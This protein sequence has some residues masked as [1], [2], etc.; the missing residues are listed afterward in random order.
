MAPVPTQNVEMIEGSLV[1][2]AEQLWSAWRCKSEELFYKSERRR[3][4]LVTLIFGNV[5]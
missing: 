2:R 5:A 3:I 1:D 4:E